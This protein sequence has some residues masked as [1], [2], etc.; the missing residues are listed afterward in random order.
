M[1]KDIE[2]IGLDN[3]AREILRN[4]RELGWFEEDLDLMKFALSY[5]IKNKLDLLESSFT[6]SHNTASFD[7]D[8][9]VKDLIQLY[10]PEE[11]QVYRFAQGL[12]NQGLI[13]IGKKLDEDQGDFL[14]DSYLD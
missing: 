4:I 7:K 1:K 6:T 11:E 14:L 8:G 13:H 2:Q 9:K 3:T 12:M 5:A 10:Y